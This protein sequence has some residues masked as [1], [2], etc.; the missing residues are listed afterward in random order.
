MCAAA[1][2]RQ[3]D[4][5]DFTSSTSSGQ[6]RSPVL[7]VV[8][9]WVGIYSGDHAARLPDLCYYH[10]AILTTKALPM[11]MTRAHPNHGRVQQ[12]REGGQEEGG[13]EV[14]ART[15]RGEGR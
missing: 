14:A 8:G 10:R 9:A 13:R 3:T 1:K 11:R 6:H 15:G 5:V 12:G 7:D 4:E 2:R